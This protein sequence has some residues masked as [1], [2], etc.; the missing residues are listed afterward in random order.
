MVTLV[1]IAFT[2]ILS[3][4]ALRDKPTLEKLWFEPFQVQYN[5]E[6]YRFISHGFVHGSGAHLFVN[7]FVFWMF[8]R[9]VEA[10]LG[11]VTG[12]PM[13]MFLLLYLGAIAVA[14]LPGYLRHRN[15]PEYR[16]VGAS[17]AVAAVLFASIVLDPLDPMYIMFVPIPIPGWL[18]GIGYLVY[19][20]VQDK[21]RQ[22]NIAHD[23]HFVGAL[24]GVLFMAALRPGLLPAMVERIIGSWS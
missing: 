21:R 2:V 14:A 23:A 22:G 11:S 20:Y 16:A 17:G 1:I 9:K 18:V 19:E 4:R 10:Q 13:V 8:G 24:F 15:N 6:Y 5:K 12:M 3:M 7:M